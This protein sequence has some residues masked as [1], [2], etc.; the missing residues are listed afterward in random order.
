MYT[1]CPN[2]RTT[3]AVTD[4]QLQVRGGV[5]RCGEC[6]HVFRAD[7]YLMDSLPVSKGTHRGQRT[8]VEKAGKTGAASGKPSADSKQDRLSSQL[9]TLDE[10][11]WGRKR[12][13]IRPVFWVAGNLL[14]LVF[15]GVQFVYFYSTELAQNVELKPYIQKACDRLGCTIRPRIDAGLI[16]LTRVRIS[17]HPRYIKVLRLRASLI[18]R[19]SFSQPFPLMEVTLSDRRGRLVGRRTFRPEEYLKKANNELREMIPNVIARA[20][21]EFTNPNLY[22][23]G[24]EIRLI[25]DPVYLAS[26]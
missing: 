6:R 14:V 16:E 7:R 10:L 8:V 11:L 2:C 12:S 22:T 26:R 17:P 4:E 19:A 1:R 15:L 18:N 21:L 20:R 9:P 23:D 3:F 25:A 5:V 13:R 24:F